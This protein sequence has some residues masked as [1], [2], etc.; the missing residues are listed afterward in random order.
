MDILTHTAIGLVG[1]AVLMPHDPI[2]AMA[3]VFGSVAPDLD[4]LARVFGA[5]RY[6]RLHQTWS[7]ALPVHAGLGVLLA[8]LAGFGV[9][10]AGWWPLALFLGLAV[11]AL[12]DACNTYG[13]SLWL[14]F[15][16]RRVHGDA[17][18]FIDSVF[19]LLLAPATG[20]SLM[21]FMQIMPWPPV[22]VAVSTFSALALYL[23]WRIWL[24]QRASCALRADGH[25]VLAAVPSA[26][27]P[28]DFLVVLD[29]DEP[30]TRIIARWRQLAGG[31][32]VQARSVQV[33]D[34]AVV[35]HLQRLPQWRF[36]RAMST[37]YHVT[38]RY[39]HADGTRWH[40]HDLRVRN[41]NTSF[42]SLT[43]TIDHAGEVQVERFAI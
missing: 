39:D 1:G 40:C 26:L 35:E 32:L 38:G 30:S 21:A 7:H 13:I 14:P 4:A 6:L 43:V 5:Q 33:L 19:M 23:C 16:S 17:I 9:V 11:H 37:A 28:W 41:F 31:Q 25:R 15:G 42:A 22:L 18:F 3:F 20:W 34:E 10:P 24:R 27:Q 2:S 29:G 12:L 8:G 36:M